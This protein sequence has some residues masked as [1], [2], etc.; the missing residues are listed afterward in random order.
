MS[1]LLNNA[2]NFLHDAR[3]DFEE[4]IWNLSVFHSEQALQLCVKYKLYIHLGDYPKTHDLKIL[5]SNL[6]RFEKVKIDELMLDFL[7]QSYISS[8]YL[9]YTFSKESAEKAL[10]FVENIMRSLGCL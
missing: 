5:I 10:N 9:P 8:R 4:G 6:G 2:K 3:R 1:F 7:V